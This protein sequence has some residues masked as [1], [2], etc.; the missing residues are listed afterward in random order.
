MVKRGVTQD[1]R[2]IGISTAL[3]DVIDGFGRGI[4]R[5]RH[6]YVRKEERVTAISYHKTVN[7]LRDLCQPAPSPFERSEWFALL[8]DAG[9]MPLVALASDGD[10][11]AALALTE[12]D[13]RIEPLRSWYSF[14]WRQLAPGGP[15]GQEMLVDIARQLRERAHRVTLW[16]VP[17]EDGSA[18]RLEAA[19]AKAG[20]SVLR[21]QCDHNHVLEVGDRSFADYWSQRPGRMRTTLKRK[22]KKVDVEVLTQ[23]DEAGWAAYERIYAD[24]W[25]PEEGDPAMLRRFAEEEGMAGRLRLGIARHE[26]NPVAAQ[27]WTVEN[28]TAYIHKLAHL[29]DMKH[30]SAGTTLSAALFEHAIDV[31]HAKLI[32]FG[33]GNDGYKAD[34]MEQVRPRYRIDCLDPR[35]S[36]A[37]PALAKRKLRQLAN[38][39]GQG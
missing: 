12:C 38:H 2:L 24:S 33:T 11:H 15:R 1:Q 18:T 4:E 8:E 39:G 21:E 5:G 31:D 32:D 22:A 37:W 34:W 25:K 27:F 9:M 28:G 36:A 10:E 13:G 16:P 30:L 17:D 7:V 29:E 14:T 23:F 3:G 19:F 35:Q 6:Q 20:W 26:G